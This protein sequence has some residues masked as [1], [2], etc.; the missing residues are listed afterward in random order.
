MPKI[1][2]ASQR[3]VLDRG[4]FIIRFF[5]LGNVLPDNN[6]HGMFQLGRVDH[7]T[8]KSGTI[9]PMHLHQ[10]DEILSY[11]R[12]G[13]M[14]HKDSQGHNVEIHQQYLMMMNAGAGFY[15][16]E[17]VPKGSET[18]EMLQIFMRPRAD[19]LH[20]RVQFHH[21]EEAYSKNEWRL[22]GA[23]ETS[24]APLKIN[25]DIEVF[26]IRIQGNIEVETPKLKR[27]QIGYLYVIDGSLEVSEQ[28]KSLLKGD[29]LILENE[30]L[31][32]KSGHQADVI[33]FI[34]DKISKVSK[35]GLYAK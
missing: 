14:I 29:A 35:N 30:S 13:R 33:L 21:F 31:A 19:G 9:V 12:K 22:I 8:L 34:L 26:D 7:A 6:D 2:R 24:Q 25:S 32:V 5:A 16:E 11:M 15:H 20:P 28:M 27:N 17:T 1:I 3:Q 4:K 23:N 10:N 18:V